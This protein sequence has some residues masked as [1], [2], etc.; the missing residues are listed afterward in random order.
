MEEKKQ[1]SALTIDRAAFLLLRVKKAFKK[2]KLQKKERERSLK[3]SSVKNLDLS[4][5]EKP[6]P[7]ENEDSKQPISIETIDHQENEDEVKQL[8]HIEAN[9]EDV[10]LSLAEASADLEK[11]NKISAKIEELIKELHKLDIK[12]AENERRKNDLEKE[13]F[14][15]FQKL[16]K[17]KK[18]LIKTNNS[19]HYFK[20][21]DELE[22][23]IKQYFENLDAKN[24]QDLTKNLKEMINKLASIDNISEEII[25][26][27]ASISGAMAKLEEKHTEV[28]MYQKIRKLEEKFA[29]V[30][31]DLKT[32]LGDISDVC[33][34]ISSK[35]LTLR[36]KI[37]KLLT[38]TSS[39]AEIEDNVVK[40]RA[41]VRVFMDVETSDEYFELMESLVENSQA[42]EELKCDDN[43]KRSELLKEIIFLQS[44]LD[45]T[46]SEVN[47]LKSI[48]E[49]VEEISSGG[50]ASSQ[51]VEEVLKRLKTDLVRLEVGEKLLTMR[52][53]CFK[54]I[55]QCESQIKMYV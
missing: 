5:L 15:T 34:E 54:K 27:K 37:L 6:Q 2:K 9:L 28:K 45:K 3:R 52:D 26:R 8:N 24:C 33:D 44:D 41:R 20:Q 19:D 47:E 11:L 55:A 43:E 21:L 4:S 18:H 36:R 42:L 38:N 22:A 30:L 39:L 16:I 48:E 50:E 12:D 46:V 31:V 40:L 51:Y 23:T 29:K 49:A 17:N 1:Y 7:S 32:E 13:F 53:E 35:K 25:E 14:H 10:K